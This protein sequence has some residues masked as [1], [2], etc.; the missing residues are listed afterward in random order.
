MK[1]SRVLIVEDDESISKLVVDH[2]TRAG[3][4]VHAASD[5]PSALKHIKDEGLPH[6]ALI[7]LM[8]PNNMHGFEFSGKLKAMA[9]V[10]IIFLTAVRDTDTIVQGLRHYAEDFVV[11]PF[12]TRELE[13]RIK[14]VLARMPTFDYVNE[15]VI[16][17]DSHLQIDFAHNRVIIDDKSITLTPIESVLLHVLVRST[18]RVVENRTL[19]TRV[20][21]DKDVN[22]DTL[23]VHMHRLRR[24]LEADSHHPHYVRTE[25]GVGYLFTVK[26]EASNPD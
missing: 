13:A 23:R 18:G 8:L 6:I 16:T 24:K 21:P 2:L 26:P 14:V 12:D 7:D 10:P 25:R 1:K 19:I 22:D 17:I 9:D 4:D 11:K 20:W 15:P 5:G 3:Y